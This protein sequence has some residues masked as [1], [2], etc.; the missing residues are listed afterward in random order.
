MTRPFDPSS[1]PAGA[2]IVLPAAGLGL[3]GARPLPMVPK[4]GANDVNAPPAA[5]LCTLLYLY[6]ADAFHKQIL[7]SWE[8][9]LTQDLRARSLGRHGR[10]EL[11]VG[12]QPS[13]VAQHEPPVA[14]S[15]VPISPAKHRMKGAVGTFLVKTFSFQSRGLHRLTSGLGLWGSRFVCLFSG[16]AFMVTLHIAPTGCAVTRT[17]HLC[18]EGSRAP[19]PRTLNAS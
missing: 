14:Q 13:R 11:L 19:K 8:R 6:L 5:L 15:A 16:G 3:A 9:G 12:N 1:C 2:P 4:I 18:A 7:V 17:V 10:R